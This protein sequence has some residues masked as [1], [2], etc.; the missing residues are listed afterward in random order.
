M[1]GNGW[2]TPNKS[3]H[4][5]RRMTVDGMK[6]SEPLTFMNRGRRRRKGAILRWKKNCGVRIS[7]KEVE[8]STRGGKINV[9][10]VEE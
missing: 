9:E 2:K 1:L 8:D 3:K 5:L 6:E 10:D 4:L 7:V